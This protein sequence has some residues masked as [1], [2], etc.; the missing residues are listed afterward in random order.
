MKAIWNGATLIESDDTAFVEGNH[1]FPIDKIKT[2]YFK[3]S[4]TTTVCPWK[5]VANYFDIVVDG[6]TNNDAAWT[7]HMPKPGAE[8][9]SGR[10]AFW[11]GVKVTQ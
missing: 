7:Y 4:A 3:P 5:G 8:A 10:I 6:Q 2:A 11:N 1:Y 9:V